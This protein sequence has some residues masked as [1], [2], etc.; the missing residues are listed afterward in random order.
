[1]ANGAHTFSADLVRRF[2]ELL[3]QHF[4]LNELSE[5]CADFQIDFDDIAGNTKN[6]KALELVKYMQR[7][8]KL[9]ALIKRVI[10]LRADVDWEQELGAEVLPY[11]NKT[12]SAKPPTKTADLESD[13]AESKSIIIN[14]N[15][16][17]VIQGNVE[18][19]GDFI[20]RDQ[21][22]HIERSVNVLPTLPPLEKHLVEQI[23][24][25]AAAPKQAEV[26]AAFRV[27]VQIRI[28][29]AGPLVIAELDQVAESEGQVFRSDE[30]DVVRYRVQISATNCDVVGSPTYEFWLKRGQ[31]SVI[32]NFILQPRKE[33]LVLITV[34]AFQDEGDLLAAS[35]FAQEM[36]T[37]LTSTP[38][39]KADS[40]TK[41]NRTQLAD[42]ENMDIT[43]NDVVEKDLVV[44]IKRDTASLPIANT[45]IL[46]VAANPT[47][48]TRLRLGKEF[49]EIKAELERGNNRD[50]VN[51]VLPQLATQAKDLTRDLLKEKPTIVHFS[52]HGEKSGAIYLE[53]DSGNSNVVSAQ[54]LGDVFEALDEQVQ[55]VILNACYSATQAQAIAKHIPY[56]IGMSHAIP[57]TFAIA[58]AIG[59]YQALANGTS[60]EQAYKLGKAQIGLA[61]G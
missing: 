18:I 1:M 3:S 46:F 33:G 41:L 22:T 59:F 44:L 21:I 12:Q 37:V 58:F 61:G 25:F 15:G 4:N 11:I 8:G 56:V 29:T 34:N 5:L 35:T 27:A 30:K 24:L 57:D 42:N 28:P 2:R 49:D 20:G 55:C 7:R 13:I 36:V 43:A 17:A 23:K 31:N 6:I 32:Q 39:T 19:K 26:G 50:K 52:G 10:E 51:L 60:F 16:G 53:T 9:E 47:D 45:K 40:V 38:A 54:A 48:T 14:T